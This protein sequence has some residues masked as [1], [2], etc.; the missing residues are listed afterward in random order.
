[1][2]AKLINYILEYD[3]TQFLGIF[4]P[5]QYCSGDY[6]QRSYKKLTKG[7]IFSVNEID[8]KTNLPIFYK[9][10]NIIVDKNSTLLFVSDGDIITIDANYNKR[11]KVILPN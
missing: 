9:L 8:K 6:V 1:M 2:K 5:K 3:T 11:I 10:D 4:S 7:T